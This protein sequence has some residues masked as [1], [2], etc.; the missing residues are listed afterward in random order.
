MVKL[1]FKQ[2][3]PRPTELSPEDIR[4]LKGEMLE[5][6]ADGDNLS[7]ADFA[8]KIGEKEIA[9][10]LLEK[11][12]FYSSALRLTVGEQDRGAL[13]ERAIQFY[14][15]RKLYKPAIGFAS[16]VGQK[17]R[18]ISMANNLAAESIRNGRYYEAAGYYMIVKDEKNVEAAMAKWRETRRK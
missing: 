5:S 15:E 17:P 8:T 18:A 14:L 13:M 10:E 12:R 3:I 16:E 11:E 2:G 4:F 1:G 7:A 9:K 6:I